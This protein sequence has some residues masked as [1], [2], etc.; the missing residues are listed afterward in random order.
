MARVDPLSPVE[1]PLS[2]AE[3]VRSAALCELTALRA[4]L[5]RG[6]VPRALLLR[7][8]DGA[9]ERVEAVE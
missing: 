7:A 3:R 1:V 6:D 8:L 2:M 9:I 4:E 5:A